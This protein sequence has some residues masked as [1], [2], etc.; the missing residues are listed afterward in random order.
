M[1]GPRSQVISQRA[2]PRAEVL[3]NSVQLPGGPFVV[4][5]GAS[6]YAGPTPPLLGQEA[7][8]ARFLQ[9]MA[10]RVEDFVAQERRGTGEY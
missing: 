3:C 6:G 2:D 5:R 7:P 10:P 9:Q 8:A 4:D 1:H